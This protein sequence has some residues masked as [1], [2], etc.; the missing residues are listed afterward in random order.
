M[1]SV[2]KVH[3]ALL[4]DPEAANEP[5]WDHGCDPPLCYA[6]HLRCGAD[7]VKLLLDHG[8]HPDSR[9]MHGRT[10]AEILRQLT[11]M[12][13]EHPWESFLPPCHQP[14]FPR[15]FNDVYETWRQEVTDL[16]RA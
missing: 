13:F 15:G 7:I 1:K 9:D 16:M 14:I 2:E 12:N 3:A 10:P 5:F 8:A 6:V 4:E 11:P